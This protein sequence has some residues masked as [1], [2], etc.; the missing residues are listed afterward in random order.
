MPPTPPIQLL[1]LRLGT[2]RF[3]IF[4]F[5]N[6]PQSF[7]QSLEIEKNTQKNSLYFIIL[8]LVKPTKLVSFQNISESLKGQY[9]TIQII[10]QIHIICDIFGLQ[11]KICCVININRVYI[12]FR[13]Q[14]FLF[15]L[16]FSKCIRDRQDGKIRVF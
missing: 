5:R 4:R 11:P 10:L 6:S 15:V 12:Q 3:Y 13:Q 14:H 1:K 7:R 2:C 8:C 9:R 16:L